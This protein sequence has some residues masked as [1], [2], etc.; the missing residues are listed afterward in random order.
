MNRED[1]FATIVELLRRDY[2]VK[3]SQLCELFGASD[4]TVRRDLD[5][6]ERSGILKR[7]HGG[8]IDMKAR[9]I[10]EVHVND[11]VYENT[12]AKER[13]AKKAYSLISEGETLYIDCGSTCYTL[14]RYLASNPI[15]IHCIT[16]S[17]NGAIELSKTK[18]VRTTIIGGELK[19]IAQCN[20]GPVAEAQIKACS[21][22]ICFIACNAIDTSGNVMLLDISE[23]ASK[24]NAMNISKKKYLLC[25]ST[26]VSSVSMINFAKVQEYTGIIVDKGISEENVKMLEENG[27][28]LILA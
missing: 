25:D 8:A 4:M 6:L 19:G 10:I 18:T 22:D 11:R 12:L 14:A 2:Y 23:R 17:L 1:R 16:N 9:N 3:N 28:S 24:R 26:K 27:A 20:Y 21:A 5:E 15:A 13:I 7:V